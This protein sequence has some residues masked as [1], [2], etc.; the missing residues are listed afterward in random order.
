M[1][2]HKLSRKEINERINRFWD[3]ESFYPFPKPRNDIQ[4]PCCRTEDIILKH[5]SYF[6][7]ESSPG[8]YRVD[9]HFKCCICSMAWTHGVPI[10]EKNY[11]D[12]DGRPHYI[13]MWTWR[14]ANDYHRNNT[15]SQP[16]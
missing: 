7:K 4:C 10:S 15:P 6:E 9:V 12:A 5:F 2:G 14:E 16:D 13:R 3:F 11:F 1:I 8:D